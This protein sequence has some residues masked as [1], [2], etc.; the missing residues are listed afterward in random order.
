MSLSSRVRVALAITTFV[1]LAACTPDKTVA[2]EPRV[3]ASINIQQGEVPERGSETH[4][5][6]WS[7]QPDS[8]LFAHAATLDTVFAIGIKAPGSRRGVYHGG[9]LVDP[10]TWTGAR[11]QVA[12]RYGLRIVTIDTLL[13][14]IR[15][16]I[17]NVEALALIRTTSSFQRRRAT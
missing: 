2:P 16:K 3:S 9:P 13:P 12:A 4:L 1:L 5:P 15:A 6:Q 10:T 7:T 8:I 11:A 17:T 14:I